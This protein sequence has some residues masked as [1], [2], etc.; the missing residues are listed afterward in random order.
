M[1]CWPD[2]LWNARRRRRHR[3]WYCVD[4][5]WDAN[6]LGKEYQ[7]RCF[8]VTSDEMAQDHQWD[9][10]NVPEAVTEGNGKA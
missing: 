2:S 3:K 8:N 7:W 10:V 4:P 1:S 9:Y 5:T 6:G